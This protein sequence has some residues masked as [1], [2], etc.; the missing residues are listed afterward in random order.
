MFMVSPGTRSLRERH[1]ADRRPWGAS[2]P[3]SSNGAQ[4]GARARP[5]AD[6]KL[7]RQVRLTDS[8]VQAPGHRLLGHPDRPTATPRGRTGRSTGAT[9]AARDDPWRSPHLSTPSWSGAAATTVIQRL[10]MPPL[11]RATDWLNSAPIETADLRGHVV[12][13]DFWSGRS[14]PPAWERGRASPAPGGAG[15]VRRPSKRPQVVDEQVP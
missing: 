8:P 4:P 5:L 1:G 3:P 7:P 13:V 15:V 6:P 12:L 9:A 11:A 14:R 2:S 10:Q